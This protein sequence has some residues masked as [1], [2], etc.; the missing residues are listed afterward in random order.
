MRRTADA[1]PPS[2][3]NAQ[4]G[5]HRCSHTRTTTNSL[6]YLTVP[7]EDLHTSEARACMYALPRGR[8]RSV[9]VHVADLACQGPARR[10]AGTQRSMPIIPPRA[11][12]HNAQAAMHMPGRHHCR[13]HP[14]CTGAPTG[15]RSLAL[16]TL[17]GPRCCEP[18]LRSSVK[19]YDL[20]GP[21]CNPHINAATSHSISSQ[22]L[23]A[24]V[25]P[26]V[27]LYTCR[28]SPLLLLL[29][30]HHAP[31]VGAAHVPATAAAIVGVTSAGHSL[32]KPAVSRVSRA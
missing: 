6:H 18:A 27:T 5:S 3:D 2:H 25:A 9:H 13:H 31:H 1:Q 30:L 15:G 22:A 23:L 4:Y 32:S 20:P 12:G 16:W 11:V 21:G 7:C 28:T 17:A 29:R 8:S 19:T 14:P 24:T 10:A 26:C